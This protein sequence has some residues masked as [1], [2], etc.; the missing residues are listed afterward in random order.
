MLLCMPG[1]FRMA[2][3]IN[4]GSVN[5]KKIQ[6]EL[7]FYNGDRFTDDENLSYAE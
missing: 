6:Y 2:L 7:L 5:R 4:P 1:V 3:V